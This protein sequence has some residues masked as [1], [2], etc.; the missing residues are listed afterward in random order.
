MLD[1]QLIIK[2]R[3]IRNLP[4]QDLFELVLC[5]GVLF[6]SISQFQAELC[7]VLILHFLGQA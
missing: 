2:L 4:L 1:L 7:R 5:L 3:F 6:G